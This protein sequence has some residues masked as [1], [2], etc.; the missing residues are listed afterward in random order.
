MWFFDRHP[1]ATGI[2]CFSLQ[3]SHGR[4]DQPAVLRTS[5][6]GGTLRVHVPNDHILTQNL[7]YNY[8]YPKSKYLIIGTWTL[9]ETASS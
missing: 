8:Y 2:Q 5:N 4:L 6:S 7:Y 3:L 9:R 1:E